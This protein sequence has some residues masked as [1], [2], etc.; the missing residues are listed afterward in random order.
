MIISLHRIG[1]WCHKRHVPLLPF[2]IKAFNRIV[3][4]AVLPPGATLGKNVVLGYQGL[5]TVIH[6]RAIIGDGVVIGHGV[7]I[8]GR[9]G[10]KQVPEIGEGAMIGAGAKVLG[11]V[12]IGRQASIGA[13][14]V[15]LA[16]VPDYG[17]AVGVPAKTI[18]IDR[19]DT[20]PD[21]Q[22]FK[23]NKEPS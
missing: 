3:F 23:N 12:R 5:G 19:P 18:R 1:H 16:D 21:Y 11:A 13:N 22:A 4:G 10:Q 14:A 7:T 8:G 20:M 9:S 17:V 2:L 15:V 6:R